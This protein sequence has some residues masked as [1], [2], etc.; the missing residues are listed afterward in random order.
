MEELDFGNIVLF[1]CY[2]VILIISI[3]ANSLI[4]LSVSFFKDLRTPVNLLVCNLSL[5]SLAISVL[6]IP[7]KLTSY[8]NPSQVSLQNKSIHFCRFLQII[9]GACI[10]SISLTLIIIC[11]DRYIA[12]IYPMKRHWKITSK[13]V[14]VFLIPCWIAAFGLSTVYILFLHIRSFYG[15]TYY[16]SRYPGS[17]LD[18]NITDNYHNLV[19]VI[20]FNRLLYWIAF[21]LIAFL[22]PSLAMMVLYSMIAGRLWF[23][24]NPSDRLSTLTLREQ[25]NQLKQNRSVI[26]TLI[27][28]F[29]IFIITNLPFYVIVMLADLRIPLPLPTTVGLA[30]RI[31]GMINLSAVAFNPIIYG[32]SN[33]SI[34][35]GIYR[36]LLCLCCNR[37]LDRRDKFNTT[38]RIPR[39]GSRSFT[40]VVWNTALE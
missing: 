5:A 16:L 39:L 31:L 24:R 36:I 4:I 33:K 20:S 18:I 32:F 40:T 15:R 10:I 7:F 35:Q 23:H 28:C 19:S 6:H 17:H 9:P 8:L 37:R 2:V 29:A 34:T 1:L 11:I 12:I 27:T 26:K 38:I 21:I 14:Y 25:Y 3:P 22:L 13:R 30:I